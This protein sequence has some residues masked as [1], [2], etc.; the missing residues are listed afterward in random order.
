MI[1]LVSMTLCDTM[2]SGP[3]GLHRDIEDV[4]MQRESI[5][6]DAVSGYARAEKRV[7][8]RLAESERPENPALQAVCPCGDH[9]TRWIAPVISDVVCV[10]W[11]IHSIH[12]CHQSPEISKYSAGSA[13]PGVEHRS[14]ECL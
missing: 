6:E 11:S 10:G 13:D 12:T 14:G 2:V 4:A 9:S 3:S 5:E 7:H 8:G 1:S